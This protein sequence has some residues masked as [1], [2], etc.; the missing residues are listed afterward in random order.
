MTLR[1]GTR[2]SALARAQADL[3][4]RAVGVDAE[5]RVVRTAGDAS[6][7]PIPELGDGVFVTA[8]EDALRRGEIDV[9]VHS[10]KDLPTEER[11][12]LV[13]AAV[14]QRED[15]R[16]VLVTRSRGGIATLPQGA[17]VGTSSPR[18]DAFLRALRPD[19]V[20]RPIRGNVDTRMA[21]VRSGEYDATILALAGLR[22]LD[23]AVA[24]EEI[25]DPRECPP[26]PG[27]GALAV[28]CRA[29]DEETRAL[30]GRLDHAPTRRAVEAERELLRLLGASCEIPLGTYA[31]VDG[32]RIVLDAALPRDGRMLRAHASGDDPLALARECAA[33]LEAG[34]HA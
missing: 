17:L 31:R 30:L 18:R 8:I 3:V 19:V 32:D 26:A 10:L 1:I 5:V 9:A 28:Q 23:I 16:D 24:D 33:A 29:D 2:G 12:G 4:A 20:T 25:L 15:P 14:P 21:K 13:I 6:D 34:V 27:Q 22:R 11:P 7:R